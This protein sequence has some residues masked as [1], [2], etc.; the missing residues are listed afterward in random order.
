MSLERELIQSGITTAQAR[1]LARSVDWISINEKWTPATSTSITVPAGAENRFKKWGKVRLKQSSGSTK[2]FYVYTLSTNT[3]FVTGG[4]DYTIATGGSEFIDNIEYSEAAQ[5]PFFEQYFAWD[6][7]PVA[8]AGSLANINKISYFRHEWGKCFIT[9][10]VQADQQT[11]N[12]NYWQVDLPPGIDT[13]DAIGHG[14]SGYCRVN[15]GASQQLS[16]LIQLDTINKRL[17][18]QAYTL[19]PFIAGSTGDIIEIGGVVL[20]D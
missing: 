14:I 20:L 10:Y 19:L 11:L 2:Q 3:L 7:N 6:C 9:I 8:S 18:V 1:I 4:T 17:Y 5:P 12:A 15:G 13:S 16:A